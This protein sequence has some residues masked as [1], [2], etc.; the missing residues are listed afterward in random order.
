MARAQ[1]SQRVANVGRVTVELGSVLGAI[2]LGLIAVVGWA[3]PRWTREGR[4]LA[5]IRRLG[6]AHALLPDSRERARLG[7]E[8]TTL[9][10]D[11][12][13][14]NGA[15]QRGARRWRIGSAIGA[16]ILAYGVVLGVWSSVGPDLIEAWVAA[17]IIGAVAGAIS[18]AVTEIAERVIERRALAQE[19]VAKERAFKEGKSLELP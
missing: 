5:R 19:R 14:W 9:A 15:D 6:E 13:V 2:A 10:R 12:N 7:A 11:L 8:I 1:T 4:L 3:G 16:L 18:A 17:L